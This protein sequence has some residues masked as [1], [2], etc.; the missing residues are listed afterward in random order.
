MN[1]ETLNNLL[2]VDFRDQ[3]INAVKIKYELDFS[4]SLLYMHCIVT[5]TTL[6]G[7]SN[8]LYKCFSVDRGLKVKGLY[9]ITRV[10]NQFVY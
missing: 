5:H 8:C 2:N 3:F 10:D 4:Y 1:Y 6:E 9:L 7:L